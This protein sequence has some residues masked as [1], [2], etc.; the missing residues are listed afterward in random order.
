MPEHLTYN[1]S[2]QGGDGG[3]ERGRVCVRES[4]SWGRGWRGARSPK[5]MRFSLYSHYI[6]G[7]PN[8]EE[9]AGSSRRRGA[10]NQSINFKLYLRDQPGDLGAGRVSRSAIVDLITS[11][12]LC[13]RQSE[14]RETERAR[15]SVCV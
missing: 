13:A 10:A 2:K 5:P 15:E 9:L 4:E 12:G 7:A 11:R 6:H 1:K 3:R 14:G 8:E